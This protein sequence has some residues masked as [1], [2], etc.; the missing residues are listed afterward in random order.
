LP[1]LLCQWLVVQAAQPLRERKSVTA[2]MASKS[3]LISIVTVVF[4]AEKVLE[5]TLRSAVSQTYKHIELVIIDGG[6][7]DNSV[8]IANQFSP[9]IGYLVS[10]PDKGIY[11]AMNKGIQAAKGEWIYFLNAGDAFYHENVLMEIF[12]KDQG[13][14]EFLYGKVQTINEP[15]G[16]NYING[17]HVNINRFYNGFPICH[18]ATF[19]RKSA[20]D[21]IGLYDLRYRLVADHQW[22]VR[23]FKDAPDKAVFMDI[24]VA[25]YDIQGT[26]YHKRMQSQQELIHYG[27]ELFP[28]WVRIVNVLGYP[29]T[30]TKV[31]IIRTF[32]QTI[33]FKHYRKWK[34][35]RSSN[36]RVLEV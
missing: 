30:Y 29:F 34:F 5:A 27:N 15:T 36:Q 8:A 31:W 35:S 22:F 26:S 2:R 19:T 3:P 7:K 33:L 32:Q 14:A 12:Q 1:W 25:Y 6:S 24:V 13:N 4:N 23:F 10:E 11:D 16:I 17:G 18:Q 21:R 20:F 9:Y 28:F